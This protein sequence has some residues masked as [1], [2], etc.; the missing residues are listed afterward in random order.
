MQEN[1]TYNQII[2]FVNNVPIKCHHIKRSFIDEGH[3]ILIIEDSKKITISVKRIDASG[4]R[5]RIRELVSVSVEKIFDI[6]EKSVM[7]YAE[8]K[9]I[10]YLLVRW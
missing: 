1:I 6:P 9:G 10:E 4:N 3:L 8:E 2:S 7:H 5:D